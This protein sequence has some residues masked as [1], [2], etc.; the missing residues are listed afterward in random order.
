MAEFDLVITAG[1]VIDGT[2]MPRYR[3]DVGVKDG[4]IAKIGHLKKHQAKSSIDADGLNV[5]PVFGDLHTH[6]DAQVFWGSYCTMSSGLGVA[7]VVIGNWEFGFA[8]VKPELR[9]RAM[10][11]MTRGEAI[12]HA[13]MK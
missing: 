4:K 5:V 3:A 1:M 13:S 6:Y 8:P 2:R 11:T 12:P 10:L 9:E 7:L